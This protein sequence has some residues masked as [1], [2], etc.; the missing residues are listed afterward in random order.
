MRIDRLDLTAFGP[1]AGQSLRMDGGDYGLHVVYG[2]NEAGKST[3]LRALVQLLFGI[4]HNSGDNF[5]HANGDLRIGAR[6]RGASSTVLDC[7]R[8]KGKSNT[9][10]GPDDVAIIEPSRLA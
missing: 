3:A 2:T 4:P 10:R 6:L 9:L 7:I 8:R 1:F 5:R